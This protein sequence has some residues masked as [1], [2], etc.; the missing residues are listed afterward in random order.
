MVWYILIRWEKGRAM[1]RQYLRRKGFGQRAQTALEY[2]IL[3]G[4]IT[5]VVLL[6]FKTFL[7]KASY[8]A[9]QYFNVVV[10]GIYG[11]P[12]R[13]IAG[14]AVAWD[15]TRQSSVDYP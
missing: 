14:N 9:E 7:P 1:R 6:A 13:K 12:A 4:S 10:C 3:L 15:R 8:E 2:V 11:P 5:V